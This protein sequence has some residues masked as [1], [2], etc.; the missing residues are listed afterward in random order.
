MTVKIL[1]KRK[2]R[3][4]KSSELDELIRKLRTLAIAQPGYVT[5][6]TL[7]SLDDPEEFL[8]ISTWVS[9]EHWRK[10]V[11]NPERSLIQDKIDILTGEETQYSIYE[12][13]V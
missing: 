13:E 10:W 6:E 2:L 4:A 11:L 5:G 8:V 7:R 1:I 3:E 12:Q 9:V